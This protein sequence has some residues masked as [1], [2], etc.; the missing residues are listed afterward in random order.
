MAETGNIILRQIECNDNTSKLSLGKSEY[1]PLKTFLKKNAFDFHQCE[2]AKTYVLVDENSVS[3]RI[4]GYITLMNSEILLNEGQR[5]QETS[6]TSKYEAFPAV[7]IARL[8]IDKG[9]QGSG[10]G[11][12]LLNWCIGHVKLA[13]MPYV[14]C[15]FLVVDAK[16]DS[17]AFYQ[18][19]G[20][21]LL[22]I[23]KKYTEEHPMMFF[24]LYQNNTA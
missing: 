23:D 14:G 22:N 9:L 3:Q 16:S 17:V 10:Y 6:N 24:D 13:I 11:A 21:E 12:K 7:K 19:S 20:F 15:R 8:A 4:W 5:P 1:T 2:I 18:K